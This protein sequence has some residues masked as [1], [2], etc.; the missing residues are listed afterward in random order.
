VLD[1]GAGP[2]LGADRMADRGATVAAVDIDRAMCRYANREYGGRVAVARGDCGRLPFDDGV[3]DVV[4]SRLTLAV[5][6]DIEAAIAEFARV[7]STDGV[8]VTSL[9]HPFTQYL[10]T[11]HG[12]KPMSGTVPKRRDVDYFETSGRL[13]YREDVD[14]LVETDGYRRPLNTVT[15]AFFDAGLCLTAVEELGPTEAIEE[16]H[17]EFS[18]RL[19]EE[20]PLYLCV[21]AEPR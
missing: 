8:V 12:K 18:R 4:V 11:V 7:L 13:V 19:H 1:A 14:E 2:G 3:F 17:T 9:D 5:L 10:S 16:R 6:P 15:D 20:P 21:R